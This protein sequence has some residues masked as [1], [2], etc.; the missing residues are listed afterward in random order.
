MGGYNTI[1]EVLSLSKKAVVVPRVT[2]VQ[3]QWIRARRMADFGLFI[4]IHPDD[5]TALSLINAV[6]EQ[7]QSD[8]RSLPPVARLDLE[9][10]PRIAYSI[11]KLVYGDP[12]FYLDRQLK[13]SEIIELYPL[14]AAS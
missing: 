6:L 3:E 1:C 9:A 13:P 11:S 14:R 7:L 4:T 10:L 2:P 5:L 8:T 12:V